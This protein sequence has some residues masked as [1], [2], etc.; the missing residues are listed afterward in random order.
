MKNRCQCCYDFDRII[1]RKNTN[2]LKYDFA[3]E[4][5]MPA[6][7][8]PLWVADMDFATCPHVREEMHKIVD[9]GIF[10]YTDVKEEYHAAVTNWFSTRFGFS[11]KG[12][13][14]VK[15]PGVVFALAAIVRALTEKGDAVLVQTPVYYPFFNVIKENGRELIESPLLY[16]NNRYTMDFEDF[17]Q[18]AQ[19][20]KLFILCSPHNP[21]GRVWTQEEL[22]RINEICLRNNVIIVSDEV[23]CDFIWWENKHTCFGTINENAIVATSP[24]KS[25][26]LAGLQASNIF[27]KNTQL[28]EKVREEISRCGYSQLNAFSTAA[29]TA[30]YTKAAPWLCA[31]KEYLQ[32]NIALVRE[33]L[34]KRMPMVKL[35]EPE[36]T[37]LVWL[38]FSAYGL[39][40]EELDRRIVHE[41]K[42]WLDGGTMFGAPGEGFQR[43]NAA[44]PR[45][46][47]KECLERLA[48]VCYD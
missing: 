31:L 19:R 12:E 36:G 4:R 8:L 37:Y 41:A 27:I 2:S 17:E 46:V 29:C 38:D 40:Q 34:A 25:F 13:E 47:L 6:D 1:D 28:R 26:N 3:I 35:V 48:R 18:K 22:T 23:H 45:S 7:V 21:V 32:G 30:A 20:A 10:G 11:A 14:I 33:F 42:L 39:P 24:S 15:T 16:E 5:G 44:C 9:H 43:I